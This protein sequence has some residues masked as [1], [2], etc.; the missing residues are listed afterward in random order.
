MSH[1]LFT[2]KQ[3]MKNEFNVLFFFYNEGIRKQTYC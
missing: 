1:I 3:Y 2:L